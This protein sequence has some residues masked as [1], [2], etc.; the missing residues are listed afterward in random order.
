MRLAFVFSSLT[1]SGG[2]LLANNYINRLAARGHTLAAVYPQGACSADMVAALSPSVQRVQA[3]VALAVGRSLAGK[4]RL[5]ASLARAIPPADIVIATHT[6]TVLPVI[7]A[8]TP[9]R[10]MRRAWLYMDYDEMFA[11][12][13]AE[14]LL[15]HRGPR[16]FDLVMTISQP[17]AEAAGQDGAKQ[18]IVT[19][20]G[21][22]RGDLFQ[23]G[24]PAAPAAAPGQPRI[25]YLGDDRPRKGLAEVLEA[26]RGLLPDWPDLR[27]VIASKQPL[28]L[29]PDLPCE[30]HLQPTDEELAALY[31]SSR[32]FVSA[33]WGEGLGYPPLE[34]MAC[35]VPTVIADSV[36]VRDYA[37]HEENCLLTPPRNPTALAVAMRRV[38][39]EPGLAARL[40]Q[41][42]S[43]TAARY[44][45]DAVIDR[46]EGA[47]L[48][49]LRG[50][51]G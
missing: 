18:V 40:V 39:S 16:W 21:L 6:P 22:A 51:T 8:T 3:G 47:L 31:R 11:G 24:F 49:L 44:R 28:A 13:P 46:C 32:L 19:G 1:L 37:R 17:L 12:R 9:R 7:L 35:G 23:P 50:R 33:S 38:L 20:A 36:G 29:P 10:Q 30:L 34:A 25:F 15:L 2:V 5:S 43:A 42:G 41:A 48:A 14:R 27:L 4:L 26:V 45:W